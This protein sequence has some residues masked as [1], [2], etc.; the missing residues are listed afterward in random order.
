MRRYSNIEN[1]CRLGDHIEFDVKIEYISLNVCVK[2]KLSRPPPRAGA[3]VELSVSF[4]YL[5]HRNRI[6]IY[7]DV[8]SVEQENKAKRAKKR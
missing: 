1:V 7:S 2:S 5:M 3:P 8:A 6:I 4:N